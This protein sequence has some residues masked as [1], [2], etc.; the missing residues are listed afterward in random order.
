MVE[1]HEK[2]LPP[3]EGMKVP[4]AIA[5]AVM[6]GL[7]ES[8][9][10]R[11]P[12]MGALISALGPSTK[13]FPV[14]LAAIALAGLV[15]AGA[16]AAVLIYPRPD[17]TLP[18]DENEGV[19]TFVTTLNEQQAQLKELQLQIDQRVAE[20]RQLLEELALR[21]PDA[22]RIQQLK[23]EIEIRDDKIDQL[24]QEITDLKLKGTAKRPPPKP[25]E[26]PSGVFSQAHNDL[27]SCLREWSRRQQG[28]VDLS[29]K[30]TV[31]A[32][33]VG[34]SVEPLPDTAGDD[35]VGPSL[36]QCAG[37]VLARVKFAPGPDNLDLHVFIVWTADSRVLS[38]SA[39]IV[40]RRK[41]TKSILD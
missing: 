5:R 17:S 11:F 36:R 8:R 34:H 12:T 6:T 29:F 33:G 39:G 10:K 35:R 1:R 18:L 16:S 28:N 32:S 25:E 37:D 9:S 7:E 22:E 13:P 26:F 23:R 27:E 19:G 3:P 14:R 2:A 31:S 40:A 20:N 38:V 21:R 41:A 15:V 30:M 4:S 24:F